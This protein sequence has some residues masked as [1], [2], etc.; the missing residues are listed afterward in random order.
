MVEI[1]DPNSLDSQAIDNRLLILP[2]ILIIALI[3]KSKLVS[4]HSSDTNLIVSRPVSHLSDEGVVVFALVKLQTGKK[5]AKEQ[6]KKLKEER[7]EREK[8]KGR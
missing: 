2:A 1:K 4:H 6:K 3:G 8:K 5:K 7:K